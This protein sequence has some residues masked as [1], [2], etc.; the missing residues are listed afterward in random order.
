MSADDIL[1]PDRLDDTPHPRERTS[2]VGHDAAEK[3]LL[4]SYRSGRMHHAW[5]IGGEEGIGKATLAYRAAR[6]ILV[7][8]DPLSD[9][10]RKAADMSVDPNAPAARRMAQQAHPDLFVLRRGFTKDGR[11]LMAE[12]SVNEARKLVSF[13]GTTAGEGGWRIAIVDTADDLN[14]NAANALLKILEE[15][16][17]RSLFFILSTAPKRLMSTIRSRCRTLLLKPLETGE[18]FEVLTGLP[19]IT[20]EATQDDLSRIADAAEGSVR[21]AA[22]M[23]AG[24]SVEMRDVVVSML[25]RLPDIDFAAVH[26]LAERVSGRDGADRFDLMV[27]LIQDWLHQRLTLGAARG[28]TRLAAW[29]GLWEKTAHTVREAETYNLDKRPLVLSLFSDLAAATRG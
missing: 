18:V 14:T 3:N 10:V 5:I 19:D 7:N 11:N 24:D 17:P 29:A 16:P 28:D 22:A 12:I 9:A 4:E 1:K 23:L 6:F 8:P 25:D 21:R 27:G 2:L 13:F 15:P 26:G 20:G